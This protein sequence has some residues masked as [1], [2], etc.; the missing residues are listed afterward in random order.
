MSEKIAPDLV[1][2][3]LL[4][5]QTTPYPFVIKLLETVFGKAPL[6]AQLTAT[7]AHHYVRRIVDCGRQPLLTP[8]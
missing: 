4:N 8:Y 6:D 3:K 7:T 5:D 1:R 2:L